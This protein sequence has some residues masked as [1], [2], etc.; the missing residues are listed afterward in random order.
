M[1]QV[2]CSRRHFGYR[3][4]AKPGGGMKIARDAAWNPIADFAT[5]EYEKLRSRLLAAARHGVV[6]ISPCISDGEREIARAALAE[7][8]PLVTMQNKGFS[9]LEKPTGRYFDAC[10][11]GR[12]L[13]LAPAA[14]PY[15]PGHKPMA[16][17]E[18]T[19]MNRLCQWIAGEGAATIN[20]RGLAPVHIDKIALAAASKAT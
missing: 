9:K 2:R 6:L 16:R 18:A 20:Y 4:I 12:L 14:W 8:L 15:V 13:M 17:H 19:A 1:V 11:A 10:A 3:R 5:P 7:G